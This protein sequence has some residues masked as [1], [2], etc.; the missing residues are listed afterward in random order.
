MEIGAV[1]RGPALAGSLLSSMSSV[2]L[3]GIPQP[4]LPWIVVA[5]Y[6]IS[7]LEQEPLRERPIPG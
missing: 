3:T 2:A 6:M 4:F 5:D 1:L 7:N